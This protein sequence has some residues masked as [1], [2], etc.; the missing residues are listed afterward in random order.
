MRTLST[1]QRT[2]TTL[3]KSIE[4]ISEHLFYL[5]TEN[6]DWT[7]FDALTGYDQWHR[8]L[9]HTPHQ[10]IK[11]TINYSM[12]IE[13]LVGKKFKQEE[14]CPSCMIGK[15]TLENY[16]ERLAPA[17]HPLERLNMESYSSSITSIE[18]YN[19]AVIFSESY[20]E[21]RWQYGMKTKDEVLGVAKRWFAEFGRNSRPT[22]Q[23]F[24]SYG[25]E[26]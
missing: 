3:P 16:P 20:G 7:T 6:M 10:N 17:S 26:T 2:R 13:G 12:G 4:F 19:H 8:R 9:G 24:C 5:Q 23:T 15:S 14:K 11:D 18:G 21:Y 1:R 25:Y 22:C